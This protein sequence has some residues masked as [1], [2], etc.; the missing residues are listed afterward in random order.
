MPTMDYDVPRFIFEGGIE[1]ARRMFEADDW[2]LYLY[3]EIMPQQCEDES[4][5]LEVSRTSRIA[6]S[7]CFLRT[8]LSTVLS[9]KS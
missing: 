8:R 4:L 5:Y 6:S 2:R 1:E 9:T 7:T 3:G